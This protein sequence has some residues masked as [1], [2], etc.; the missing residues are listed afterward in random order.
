[1]PDISL[2]KGLN[3]PIKETCLRYLLKSNEHGQSY[4]IDPPYNFEE[5]ECDYYLQ[6]KHNDLS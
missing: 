6:E 3:C 2:C 4:F 5:N 1:M